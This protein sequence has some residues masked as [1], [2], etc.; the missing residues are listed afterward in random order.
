MSCAACWVLVLEPALDENLAFLA[1]TYGFAL[2]S[3]SPLSSDMIWDPGSQSMSQVMDVV[4]DVLWINRFTF[5][6]YTF[7]WAS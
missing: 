3:E 4:N 1:V 7:Y 6:M 2:A 5:G